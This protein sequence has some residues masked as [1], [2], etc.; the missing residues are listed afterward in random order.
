MDANAEKKVLFRMEL[1]QMVD[2][3]DK[4]SL[5]NLPEIDC[6][7]RRDLCKVKCCQFSVTASE[8]DVDEGVVC[9]DPARPF[10]I[11]RRKDGS[12]VHLEQSTCAI[13]QQRPGICRLYDCRG[14]S[15][16]WIDFEARIP[17]L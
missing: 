15:R 10:R 7:A 5:R 17:A 3:P 16:I 2:I 9:W 8:Q 14:D 11:L 1:P 13:Y 6:G 4:Y 12:C